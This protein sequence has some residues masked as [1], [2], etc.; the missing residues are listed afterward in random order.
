[1][2]KFIFKKDKELIKHL[3]FSYLSCQPYLDHRAY[4]FERNNEKLIVEQDLIYPHDFPLLLTLPK[5]KK[6]WHKMNLIYTTQS[7]I[8]KI[9][10]EKIP[11]E[12]KNKLS[13]EYYYLT[14]D[15]TEPKKDFKRRVK[16]FSK[17]YPKHKIYRSYDPK[18]IINFYNF[19]FRQKK[20][21]LSPS[22]KWEANFFDFVL[23]NLKKYDIKQI[24]IEFDNKLV[25]FTWGVKHWK[26]GWVGLFLKTNY[27][28]KGLSRFLSN[29]RATLFKNI[30]YF[31]LGEAPQKNIERFKKELMPFKKTQHYYIST[32]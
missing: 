6:N 20:R 22:L 31:T 15:F 23:K 12:I 29:Q 30:K 8:K 7:Q 4:V 5:N 21:N 26:Y 24:Y 11:I 1:M 28:Y 10:K 14:K 19:W 3:P 16:Q 17:L 32:R 27:N 25:G 2:R 13:K 9:E 18:K